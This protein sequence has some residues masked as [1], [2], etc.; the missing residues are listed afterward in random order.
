MAANRTARA[1][2]SGLRDLQKCIVEG[3]AC[4]IDFSFADALL[5]TSSGSAPSMRSSSCAGFLG[6]ARVEFF[7][8]VL[9]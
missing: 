9:Q 3:W 1:A 5:I 4:L 6:L 8:Q 7:V 2:A